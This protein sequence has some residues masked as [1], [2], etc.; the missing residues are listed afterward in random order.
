MAKVILVSTHLTENVQQLALSLASQKQDVTLITSYDAEPSLQLKEVEVLTFFKKW[1]VLEA[2]RIAPLALS[3]QPQMIHFISENSQ[4]FSTGFLTFFG[5]AKAHPTTKVSFSVMSLQPQDLR[6]KRL[7]WLLSHSDLL[8]CSRLEELSY[9]RGFKSQ[10]LEQIRFILPP[11]LS[12]TNIQSDLAHRLTDQEMS[13]GSSGDPNKTFVN[14]PEEQQITLPPLPDKFEMSEAWYQ[15]FATILN[16]KPVLIQGDLSTWPVRQRKLF[17]DWASHI[18]NRFDWQFLGPQT[19][20]NQRVIWLAGLDL[21]PSLLSTYFSQ[22]LS[23]QAT[24]VLDQK[25]AQVHAGFWKHGETC[26]ILSS[27]NILSEAQQLLA[28]PH[29]D[30]SENL[31]AAK[32]ELSHWLDLPLNELTRLYN[33]ALMKI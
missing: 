27:K 19:V 33:K 30:L 2:I 26:W 20:Q 4:N 16:Q 32:P 18:Q 31:R 3:F 24:L 8:S 28:Q 13:H 25:Q 22:S 21:N 12:R 5:L 17:F 10:N 14:Q 23:L 7:K 11:F 15:I 29:L 6:Q 1:S 9:L